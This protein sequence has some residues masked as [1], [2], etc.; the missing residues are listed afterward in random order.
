MLFSYSIKKKSYIL[1][2]IKYN[3]ILK[4]FDKIF[5]LLF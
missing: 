3:I 4:E 1:I 2:K 5:K